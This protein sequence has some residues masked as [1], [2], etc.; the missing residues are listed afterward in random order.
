MDRK[1]IK[2]QTNSRVIEMNTAIW[3]RKPVNMRDKTIFKSVEILEETEKKCKIVT[4]EP[5]G[6]Q[7]KKWIFKHEILREKK[8]NS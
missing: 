3:M 6:L 4:T 5:T 7:L 1:K 8:E 2:K